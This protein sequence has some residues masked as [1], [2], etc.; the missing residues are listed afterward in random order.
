MLRINLHGYKGMMQKDDEEGE[1]A[2]YEIMVPFGD[3]LFTFD[4]VGF[5]GETDTVIIVNTVPLDKIV[6][7]LQ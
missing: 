4:S 5:E 1:G 3:S 2:N 6:K 7:L